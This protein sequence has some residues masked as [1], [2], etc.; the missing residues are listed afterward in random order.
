MSRLAPQRLEDLRALIRYHDRKYYVDAQPEISDLEYDRLMQELQTLESDHPE[1]ITPDSP[2][3]RIGDAPIAALENVPHRVPMLSIDNT[4]SLGELRQYGQRTLK[5][6]GDEPTE[7]VVELKVD[8]VAVSLLY[9]QGLLVRG[10]TRGNGRVG[11]DITHNVKT[12]GDVPLR[13]LG[14]GVPPVLE[15]RGEIYMTN[16]D[17]AALNERQRARGR[18]R[19]PTRVTAP[20]EPPSCW[21]P[22]SAPSGRC[23]CSAMAS[24]TARDWRPPTTWSSWPNCGSSACQPLRTSPASLPSTRRSR[25]ASSWP[26]ACTS[27]TSKWTAWS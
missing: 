9:E 25:T 4:Y 17:L 16:S 11:N 7:W 19:S 24:A 1:W 20:P 6:L 8:G 15:V 21:T 13:L 5:A 18:N 26:N 3:Q 14:T 27:W 12:I 2:T 10:V 23:G 22:A